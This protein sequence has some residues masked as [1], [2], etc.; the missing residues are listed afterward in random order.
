MAMLN[1][2]M[3]IFN[4]PGPALSEVPPDDFDDWLPQR[5]QASRRIWAGR[6][7]QVRTQ[8]ALKI[9]VLQLP[10]IA[11]QKCVNHIKPQNP[12]KH[13]EFIYL[14]NLLKVH[15]WTKHAIR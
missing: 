13:F 7:R 3:I 12:S 6:I 9:I 11:V 10:Q 5:T 14:Y 8:R 15:C 1:N 4:L 2:Q